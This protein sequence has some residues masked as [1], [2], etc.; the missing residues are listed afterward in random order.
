MLSKFDGSCQFDNAYMSGMIKKYMSNMVTGWRRLI[1]SPKLQIIFHNRA[2]KYKS[3]LR[4]MTYEDE[5]SYESLPPCNKYS[6][7]WVAK[8]MCNMPHKFLGS[9]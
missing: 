1:G 8:Q 3:L 5:G 6:I 2:T 9:W 4:K 7:T